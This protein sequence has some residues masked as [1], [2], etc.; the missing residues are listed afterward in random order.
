MASLNEAERTVLDPSRA[1]AR[2][3]RYVIITPARDEEKNI[4]ATIRSVA[5]Q[6]IRP[7]EWVIVNDGSTDKTAEILDQYAALY[8]W[9]RVLHLVNRGH[10]EPGS[11]VMRA[12]E[13]GLRNLESKDWEFIVKLDG[14]LSFS[15]DYFERC[16]DEFR[17]DPTLAVGGGTICHNDDGATRLETGLRFHVRGATKIYRRA[18]WDQSGG[19]ILAPGW[20][21]LD[22]VK[23]NMLGW[24][25]RSFDDITFVHR[26]PTGSADGTWRNWFKN[27]R[28]NYISG[29][30]PLFM[31][32][33]CV[34]RVVQ[35][36]YVVMACGLFSGFV[37][38][39]IKG[40]PQ[41]QDKP[42]IRYVRR[43]QLRRLLFQTSIWK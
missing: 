16:F 2:A 38:G 1:S 13:H 39:Y 10:R 17:K 24:T 36:P 42:L 12:F 28:A 6:T 30:H 25:S 23:A 4:E 27:G 9:L 5:E 26:R 15:P 40:V 11:G 33:K 20:D 3:T 21:T 22:E 7:L 19:L 8:P 32:L 29:Y 43:Q 34:K 14:D 31:L 37:S 18:F 41:V 35:R